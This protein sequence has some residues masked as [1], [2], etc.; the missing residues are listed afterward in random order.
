MSGTRAVPPEGIAEAV[1]RFEDFLRRRGFKVTRTRLWIAERVLKF[2]GHFSAA[3][4]WGALRDHR[5]SMATIYQT[6]EL[7]EQAGLLRRCAF[8]GI[9]ARYESCLGREHHG[10][11]VCR[12][13][14][15]IVEFD[16]GKV[17]ALLVKIAG[18]HGF[19][20]EE[21]VIQ[22]I[23][24]CAECRRTEGERWVPR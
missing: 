22:G 2:P 1:A 14:G 8:R 5:V 19:R 3:D 24:L 12:R 23:G 10:H 11:L 9:G 18:A 16:D 21:T 15:N 7:M 17:E 20:L 4:L 6:L 13:C